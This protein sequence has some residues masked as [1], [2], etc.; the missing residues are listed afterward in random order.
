MFPKTLELTRDGVD[1][2]VFEP[3]EVPDGDTIRVT[4]TGVVGDLKDELVVEVPVRPWGVQ[5]FASESGSASEST[6]V[7][8]GLPQGRSYDD[9]EML[10]VVSPTLERMLIELAMGNDASILRN[11]PGSSVSK[12]IIPSPGTTADR[13]AELLAATSAWGIS[14]TPSRARLPRPSGSANAPKGWLPA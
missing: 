13:A 11:E 7:F 8:V 12:C 1:E 10:I 3:F 2:V 4:L 6:T 14:A 5:A 9:P